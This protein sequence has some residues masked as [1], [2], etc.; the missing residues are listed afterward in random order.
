MLGVIFN[1]N[2]ENINSK[3]LSQGHSVI[4]QSFIYTCPE[5]KQEF[6]NAETFARSKKLGLWENFECFPQTYRAGRCRE[7]KLF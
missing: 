6:L 5:Y 3:S 4:Y 2:M 7:N 1:K